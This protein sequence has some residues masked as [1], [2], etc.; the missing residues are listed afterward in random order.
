MNA[1]NITKQALLFAL[2]VILFFAITNDI[3]L[4]GKDDDLFF[5][6]AS[7]SHFYGFLF[8]R[9]MTWSGRAIIELITIATIGNLTIVK[10]MIFASVLLICFSSCA[11]FGEGKNLK[12][13]VSFFTLFLL[14]EPNVLGNSVYWIVGYYNYLL[15][16]SLLFYAIFVYVNQTKL[17]LFQRSFQSYQL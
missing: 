14:I 8:E 3:F 11:A 6:T 1:N 9:Y 5:L 15:P 10:L 7:Q 16:F 13:I 2:L 17:V 12:Y 4:R